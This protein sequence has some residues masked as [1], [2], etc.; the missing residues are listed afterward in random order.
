MDWKRSAARGELLALYKEVDELLRPFSCPSSGEC[1]HFARTGREPYPHRVE[2][3]EVLHAAK[4]TNAMTKKRLVVMEERTCRLLGDDGRCT[5][6]ASRP[7]GCRTYFCEKIEGPRKW[8]RDQVNAIGRR[9]AD[10]SAKTYP[11]RDA[12]PRALSKAL[13]S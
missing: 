1:C 3:D 6:Y 5:I 10:L 8:P 13:S 11:D 4:A 7:F 2:L 9:I 12:G